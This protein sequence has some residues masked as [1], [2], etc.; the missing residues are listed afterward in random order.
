MAD[1]EITNQY[2]SKQDI[3]SWFETDDFP[4]EAQFRATW[5]SYRHKSESIPMN[6]IS[7]LVAKFN[8]TVSKS[9]FESHLKDENAHDTTLAKIDA[10]NIGPNQG[11]WRTA[12]GINDITP[13]DVDLTNYYTKP[14]VDGLLENVTVDLSNYYTA[15]QT[16]SAITSIIC[17]ILLWKWNLSRICKGLENVVLI[18][19]ER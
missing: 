10:S 14:E 17:S 12:L 13:P 18:G 5:D 1:I 15:S 7:G 16:E 9:T 4:T 3:Y 11:A 2:A 8:Q 6:S 19:V